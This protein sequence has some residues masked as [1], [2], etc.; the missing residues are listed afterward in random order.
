MRP[1]SLALLAGLA[2]GVSQ[3]A[4]GN[5]QIPYARAMAERHAHL[6][7]PMAWEAPAPYEGVDL[8][9]PVGR[10]A[11]LVGSVSV[12][13]RNGVPRHDSLYLHD[14]RSGAALWSAPRASRPEGE[15]RLVAEAPWLV[16]S[17]SQGTERELVAL[18][19]ATG[20]RR[21]SV[22]GRAP[23][24]LRVAGDLVLVHSP[25]EGALTALALATGKPRWSHPLD[26]KVPGRLAMAGA[27]VLVLGPTV[28][29]L[30]PSTG[31]TAWRLRH[32]SFTEPT[33]AL[34][35]G[36]DLLLWNARAL[37]RVE[38]ASGTLRWEVA[39]GG[40]GLKGVYPDQGALLCLLAG[41]APEP[42]GA[43]P[44]GDDLVQALDPSDGSTSWSRPTS[45]PV[46]SPLV[47]AAGG[48]VFTQDRV[49]TGLELATGARRFER[50]LH[51]H[52]AWASPLRQRLLGLPDRILVR[53]GGT[54]VVV[55]EKIGAVAL[56][57]ADGSPRWAQDHFGEVHGF[58]ADDGMAAL[59]RY[60]EVPASMLGS[61]GTA[62]FERP[63]P[64][65]FLAAALCSHQETMARTGRTLASARSTLQ[66]RQAAH[67]ERQLSARGAV[68]QQRLDA[69]FG[70]AQAMA[71][72]ADALGGLADALRQQKIQRRIQATV[73]R[74]QMQGRAILRA[75]EGLLQGDYL[76]EPFQAGASG[77]GATLIDLDSGRRFDWMTQPFV[78]ALSEFGG[79]GYAM[80]VDP[81]AGLVYLFG[82]SMEPLRWQ[83]R[84]KWRATLPRPSLMA[85]RIDRMAFADQKR[86]LQPPE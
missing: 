78:G 23:A 24:T 17:G 63:G 58:T 44:P 43:G 34:E 25:G 75:Q 3:S 86:P 72:F 46:A 67:Q 42:G 8:I 76:I 66:D 19:P 14:R 77:L 82:V 35:A 53:P 70:R 33:E 54:V 61:G 59:T 83:V 41:R 9:E 21:W 51:P 26:P 84:R 69:S 12:D 85:F 28:E 52:F 27:H 62:H 71:G 37:L 38:A 36:E 68:V 10:S 40:G 55:R 4:G 1:V 48:V 80:R 5:D 29:A 39:A 31:R 79:V 2:A 50:P 47:V 73:Q 7:G 74:A 60:A 16:L 30:A 11:L 20:A 45:G 13:E 22:K 81:E 57:P 15:Y 18:D 65:P 64:N 56:D 6:R 32:A 49:M